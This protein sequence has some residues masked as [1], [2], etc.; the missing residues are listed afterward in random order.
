MEIVTPI[1]FSIEYL[2]TQVK[3]QKEEKRIKKLYNLLYEYEK[4]AYVT[5]PTCNTKFLYKD[6][7]ITRWYK[8]VANC[9][10]YDGWEWDHTKTTFN[11]CN[12]DYTLE[13]TNKFFTVKPK[14][15]RYMYYSNYRWQEGKD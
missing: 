12:K 6:L 11:C 13:F 5:C 14:Q 15:I 2:K 10:I 7:I 3:I 8:Y 1:T 4:D 9:N